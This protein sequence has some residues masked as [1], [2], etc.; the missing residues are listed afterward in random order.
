METQVSGAS[1]GAAEAEMTFGAHRDLRGIPMNTGIRARLHPGI[2]CAAAIR[3]CE[4]LPNISA[5]AAGFLTETGGLYIAAHAML[6][7]AAEWECARDDGKPA[8]CCLSL[9]VQNYLSLRTSPQTGVAIPRLK[10]IR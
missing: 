1:S 7:G 2:F 8:N 10:G 9:L 3:F 4:S 5:E 6:P